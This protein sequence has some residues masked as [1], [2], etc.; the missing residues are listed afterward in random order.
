ML[1]K[2]KLSFILVFILFSCNWS[3]LE[4][5]NILLPDPLPDKFTLDFAK[6][7]DDIQWDSLYVIRPYSN[8]KLDHLKGAGQISGL[9][10]SD[11]Y[12]LVLFLDKE[13]IV[14]YTSVNRILDLGQLWNESD[15]ST[16]TRYQFSKKDSQFLF[17]KNKS[18]FKLVK[19]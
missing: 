13:K 5:K 2:N 11:L 10:N 19:K 15:S 8:P 3:P 6:E 7:V 1:I 14:G 4:E 12:I 16:R 17:Y 9:N 18:T